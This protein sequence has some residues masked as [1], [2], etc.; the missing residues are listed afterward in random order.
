MEH[1]QIIGFVLAVLVGITL[2]LLGSGGSILTVPIMVYVVGLNPVLAAAYSLFVV[3]TSALIGGF[4][5]MKEKL[6][7][8]KMVC[9]FGIPAI[10]TVFLTR[11]FVV[12][13][14]PEIVFESNNFLINK[15][16]A[17]MILFAV[18]MI[19]ASFTMIKPR[20]EKG[21]IE[22][23]PIK[24][25][26]FLILILGFSIGFLAG[27]VGAGGGFLIIPA[28]VLLTKM[29][30]KKAVGTSLF[31]V[32]LQSLIGFLGDFGSGALINWSFLLSF[33]AFAVCGIFI[34]DFLS[35]KIDGNKLKVGFGWFVLFMGIYIIG[36]EVL[37]NLKL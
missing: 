14:I 19:A 32:A 29:P 11:K 18:V 23:N 5:K 10:V 3:G 7:N 33:T 8:F 6:I 9:F 28:L 36:K 21:L 26:Y 13:S 25:N 16:F 27:L 4:K 2:G 20:R 15:S 24:H 17:L 1:N 30:M 12:P 35:K 34:G 37:K 31:I 22:N